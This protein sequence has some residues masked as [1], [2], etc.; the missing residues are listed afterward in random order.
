MAYFN[1]DIANV[2][3]CVLYMLSKFETSATVPQITTALTE[4]LSLGYFDIQLAVAELE[5]NGFIAAVPC[6]Y[7]M[8]YSITAKGDETLKNMGKNLPKSIRLTCDEYVHN[9]KLR[10]MQSEQY[11]AFTRKNPSGG[12]DVVLNAYDKDRLLLSVAINVADADIGKKMC[13]R[14]RDKSP[15]IYRIFFDVMLQEHSD[16]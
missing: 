13:N 15:E 6:A 7:G 1:D 9:N 4:G 2:K 12:Y 3:L 16:K 10:I 14:W 5:D 8:G 11:N